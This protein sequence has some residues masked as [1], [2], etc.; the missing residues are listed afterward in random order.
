MVGG[1]FKKVTLLATLPRLATRLGAEIGVRA[2]LTTGPRLARTAVRVGYELARQAGS[3]ERELLFDASGVFDSSSRKSPPVARHE[4]A[5]SPVW[6]SL[7]LFSRD[8]LRWVTPQA[9]SREPGGSSNPQAGGTP[10]LV[11]HTARFFKKGIF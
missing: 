8:V 10:Q 3:L 7:T 9:R 4:L 5:T 2:P 6:T 11:R 1:S